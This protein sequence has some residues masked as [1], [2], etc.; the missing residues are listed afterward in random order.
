MQLLVAESTGNRAQLLC[1]LLALAQCRLDDLE[2]RD[3]AQEVARGLVG[4]LVMSMRFVRGRGDGAE[5]LVRAVAI[6]TIAI[7][8]IDGCIFYGRAHACCN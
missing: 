1:E 5:S 7:G 4:R 2:T 8:A 3:I 6:H